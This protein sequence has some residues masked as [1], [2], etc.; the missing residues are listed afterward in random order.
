MTG[1]RLSAAVLL[2]LFCGGSLFSEE[3]PW[4]GIRSPHFR[5]ITNGDELNGRHVLL[6]FELMRAVFES[7]FP[8]FKLDASA[9]LL[10]IAAKDESTTRKL[11][12]QYSAHS[13]LL[14]G[15]LYH[16]GWEKQYAL[17]RLD[18]ISSDP[19]GFHTVYHEY[20]H[21]LL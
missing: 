16:D 9:P 7:Q 18:V 10:I 1:F 20:V 4:T 21:S 11:L 3:K 14:P 12:P 19:E 15:G 13:M 2:M 5:L 17:V 6:R 8:H